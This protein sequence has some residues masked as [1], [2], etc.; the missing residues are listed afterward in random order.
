MY[1]TVYDVRN[2]LTPGANPDDQSTA[3]GLEDIQIQDAIAEADGVIDSYLS[4]LYVIPDDVAGFIPG[5]PDPIAVLT[6]PYPVRWYSRDIAAWLI[7]LTF[8][9]NKDVP[10]DD[11]IRLRYNM[12]MMLLKRLADGEATLPNPPFEPPG[13]GG[14]GVTVVN[15]YNGKLFDPSDF[16]LTTSS[17]SS[18]DTIIRTQDLGWNH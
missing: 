14:G 6:A 10:P 13:S 7:T 1:S 9:R 18:S 17:Q 15:Q 8:K 4:G 11:P 2:A 3:S 12:A 5:E 16:N